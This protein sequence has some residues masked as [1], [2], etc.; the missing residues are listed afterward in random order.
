MKRLVLYLIVVFLFASTAQVV[1][2]CSMCKAA[3]ESNIKSNADFKGKGLN[4]GILYLMSIPYLLGGVA[5]F[6]Y[7]KN[8]KRKSISEGLVS[9]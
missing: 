9:Q 4:H 2:Q 5:A 6:I 7:F 1:A 8:R 3:V